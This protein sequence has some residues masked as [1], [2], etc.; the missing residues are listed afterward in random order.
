MENPAVNR[1]PVLTGS[2]ACTVVTGKKIAARIKLTGN[3]SDFL[4]EA[5]AC[6]WGKKG[7]RRQS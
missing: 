6:L 5:Y 7:W 1:L 2:T 4:F 3:S